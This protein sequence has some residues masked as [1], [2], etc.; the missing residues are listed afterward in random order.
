MGKKNESLNYLRLSSRIDAVAARM[1]TAIKMNMVTKSMAGV[2]KGMDKVLTTMDPDRITRIMDKFEQ[3]FEDM[4]VASEHMES[5]IGQSTAQTTPESEVGALMAQIADE[6]Q[7]TLQGEL[8]SAV[9]A[10]RD[11][12]GVAP[13][14]DLSERL[15]RLR[16]QPPS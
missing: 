2:V 9:A 8:D 14:D 11:P 15:A 16:Q 1:D 5:S 3:Q 6:N 10:R 4:D 7:L 13:C 12:A